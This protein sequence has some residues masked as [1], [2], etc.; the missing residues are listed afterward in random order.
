LLTFS[1]PLYWYHL[2]PERPT[3]LGYPSSVVQCGVAAGQGVTM[4][5]YNPSM[6]KPWQHE[7]RITEIRYLARDYYAIA[8]SW[9]EAELIAAVDRLSGA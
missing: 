1:A 2:P 9:Q 7:H 4:Y 3:D 6:R 8:V 5:Y